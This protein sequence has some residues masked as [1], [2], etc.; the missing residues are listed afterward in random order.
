MSIFTV[1]Y[2]TVGELREDARA[3]PAVGTD[4]EALV[5]VQLAAEQLVLALGVLG[6]QDLLAELVA[7]GGDFGELALRVKRVAEPG[8]EVA[9]R[10]QRAARALLDRVEDLAEAALHG[11][12]AAPP[13]TRRT[14]R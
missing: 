8:E 3:A 12:R 1:A 11:V 5:E 2:Q 9:H 6:L 4:A 13:A 10:L 14:T 7:L